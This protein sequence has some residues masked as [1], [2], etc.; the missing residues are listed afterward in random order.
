[1][2]PSQSQERV[3]GSIEAS[4][5]PQPKQEPREQPDHPD[6]HDLGPESDEPVILYGRLG[7]I[8]REAARRAEQAR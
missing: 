6:I 8:S 4:L 1:M 3:S 5:R 7:Y 2:T